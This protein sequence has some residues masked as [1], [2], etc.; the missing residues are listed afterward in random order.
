MSIARILGDRANLGR[1][2]SELDGQVGSAAR[3]PASARD[4][5]NLIDVGFE[6]AAALETAKRG[7]PA[8]N[9]NKIR[10]G[11][12][13]SIASLSES[14]RPLSQDNTARLGMTESVR[15]SALSVL[16]QAMDQ[17]CEGSRDEGLPTL[18]A[19]ACMFV[20]RARSSEK[21][22]VQ[23]AE[24]LGLKDALHSLKEPEQ[25]QVVIRRKQ[26]Q[27]LEKLERAAAVLQAS[28]RRLGTVI[29]DKRW[30]REVDDYCG[31]VSRVLSGDLRKPFNGTGVTAVTGSVY[32]TI[33][34]TGGV[35]ADG[36]VAKG[37]RV[38][39]TGGLAVSGDLLGRFDG[40]GDVYV[41]GNLRGVVDTTGNI[42]VAGDV[43]S[44]ATARGSAL[45]VGGSVDEKATSNATLGFVDRVFERIAFTRGGTTVDRLDSQPSYA[46][47]HQPVP[48]RAVAL[49]K[50]GRLAP[51]ELTGRERMLIRVS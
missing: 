4:L 24:K 33:N 50:L 36:K 41:G 43:T 1:S 32:A 28:K 44:G 45:F 46:I 26:A 14:V 48:A 47:E 27:E 23:L 13:K 35:I 19:Q 40:T 18:V 8:T 17:L 31:R 6:L 11:A 20:L 49:E 51:E 9:W 2:L 21:V 39:S 25:N 7:N 37:V 38:N 12:A 30:Y 5:M 22:Y 15:T 34:T 16:Q 10:D 42:Y 29:F 3:R